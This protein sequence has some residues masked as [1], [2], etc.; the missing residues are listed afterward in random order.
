MALRRRL[1][2]VASTFICVPLADAVAVRRNAGRAQTARQYM[3][4]VP[5]GRIRDDLNHLM[6]G[7]A[8]QVRLLLA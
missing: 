4:R 7:T 3:D 2:C 5:P 1:F 6:R 8:I